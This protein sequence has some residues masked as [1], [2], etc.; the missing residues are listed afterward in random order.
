VSTTLP[1]D[2]DPVSHF[3][4]S[5]NDLFDHTLHNVNDSDMVGMNI[6]NQINQNVKPNGISFRRK[7][8]LPG[9]VIRSVFEKV[10]QSNY[11]LDALDT[12]VVTV[13]SA[14]CQ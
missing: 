5:V 12:L 3:V 11:R 4:A 7:D 2:G 13:H 1:D 6:Q 14:R 10:S 9:N 8:Q